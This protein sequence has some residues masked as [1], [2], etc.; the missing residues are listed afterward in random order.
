MRWAD[1]LDEI[2]VAWPIF[3]ERGYSRDGMLAAMLNEELKLVIWHAMFEDD[4]SDNDDQPEP[5]KRK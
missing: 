3:R 4:D 5:W 2:E 1:W